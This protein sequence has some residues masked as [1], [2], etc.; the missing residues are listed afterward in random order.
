MNHN[1]ETPNLVSP[2]GFNGRMPD[3]P[4]HIVDFQNQKGVSL[5][6]SALDNGL[7]LDVG[8]ET[9]NSPTVAVPSR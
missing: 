6:T 1:E 9:G 8:M 2:S 7:M 4:R 5:G 3:D